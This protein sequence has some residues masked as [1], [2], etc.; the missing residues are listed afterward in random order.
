M[1]VDKHL[2]RTVNFSRQYF[3]NCPVELKNGDCIFVGKVIE[4]ADDHILVLVVKKDDS[5]LNTF[6]IRADGT[7]INK[8]VHW[9]NSDLKWDDYEI[10]RITREKYM[11]YR[12]KGYV[13]PNLD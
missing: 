12:L 9:T 3:M 10:N 1:K 6:Q 7:V 5:E 11:L 8:R 13:L 2:E 4:V